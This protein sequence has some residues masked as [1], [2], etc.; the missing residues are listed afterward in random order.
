LQV[1]QVHVVG[2]SLGVKPNTPLSLYFWPNEN[3]RPPREV[4]QMVDAT[5]LRPWQRCP[6][7][8]LHVSVTEDA[9]R[10]ARVPILAVFGEHD[11]IQASGAAMQ[12]VAKNFS[13]RVVP[14]FDHHTLAGS[15]EFRRALRRF[16]LDHKSPIR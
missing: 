10:S 9:L 2:Y 5:I 11:P 12:G 1:A 4:V 3:G 8:C 16:L 15:A 14:G 7:A 6:E 13:M